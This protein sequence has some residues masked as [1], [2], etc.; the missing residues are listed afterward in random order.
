MNF[1]DRM[2]EMAYG[3]TADVHDPK[4]SNRHWRAG[5]AVGLTDKDSSE[6]INEEWEDQNRPNGADG[7]PFAEWKIGFWAARFTKIDQRLK[8]KAGGSK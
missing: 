1:A 2:A 3:R 4:N 7:S 5:Y 8:Q 6:A